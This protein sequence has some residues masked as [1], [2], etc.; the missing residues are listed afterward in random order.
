MN[1]PKP[2]SLKHAAHIGICAPSSAITRERFEAGCAS[3]ADAGCS[4]V[5][6]PQTYQIAGQIAGNAEIRASALQN[7]LCDDGLDGIFCA[8]GGHRAAE[9]LPLLDWNSIAASRPKIVMGFS[10]NSVLI[11]ALAARLGWVSV[12]GPTVQYFSKLQLTDP[13]SIDFTWKL[14]RGSEPVYPL[15]YNGPLVEGRIIV[16]TLSLLPLLL[17]TSDI[18]SLHKAILCIEDCNEELSSIDRLML[19]LKR[20]GVFDQIGALVCGSFTDLTDSG[21]P[22]GFGFEDIVRHHAG[23]TPVAF[24]APFGHGDKLYALPLGVQGRLHN[25]ELTLLEAPFI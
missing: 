19:H 13:P 7:L 12:F 22:F 17:N 18:L 2:R 4:L 23:S 3:L 20:H 24:N 25:N 8:A 10:D 6:H 1:I 5:I 16:C 9:I 15:D 21:R 14:L 11:N